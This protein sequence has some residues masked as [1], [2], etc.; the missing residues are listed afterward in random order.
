TRHRGACDSKYDTKHLIHVLHVCDCARNKIVSADLAHAVNC[1]HESLHVLP[2]VCRRKNETHVICIQVR[3]LDS[4]CHKVALV[5]GQSHSTSDQ[6]RNQ[7]PCRITS[8]RRGHLPISTTHVLKRKSLTCYIG[9][10]REELSTSPVM[11]QLL[12][13][14][15]ERVQRLHLL[16]EAW[17][18]GTHV[19]ISANHIASICDH[20]V[21]STR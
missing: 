5:I 14:E 21:E 17:V 3:Q 2:I 9:V 20:L 6:L 10:I 19:A 18:D 1:S 4:F 13:N 7:S 12:D 15:R 8:H 11:E 16:R